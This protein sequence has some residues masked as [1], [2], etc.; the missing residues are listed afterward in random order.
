MDQ[1]VE[2]LHRAL[3]S[4]IRQT[5]GDDFT[6]PV[7]VSEIYQQLLPYRSAR[8]VVGFDMNADYEYALLRLLAGEGDFA[9]IEPA[10]VR[11]ILRGE[12]ETPNPNVGLFRDYANCD[13]WISAPPPWLADVL[14]EPEL[15]LPQEPQ[16][17]DETVET[18]T[19]ARPA[20]APPPAPAAPAATPSAPAAPAP[21][22]AAAA[23]QPRAAPAPSPQLR[24]C[25]YCGGKL[26][27]G[28]PVNFCPFCGKDLTRRPCPGCG[29]VMDPKW[30]F[31]ANC[32]AAAERVDAESN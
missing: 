23:P 27:A 9:R 20:P 3:V 10:E 1:S 26:P 19:A 29:E 15:E 16:T 6:Q 12:L 11:E 17:I 30:R 24:Q 13:V 22:P 14:A 31:C 28:R 32:G 2:K 8:A 25:G 7:T 18:A 5:R 4:A 21:P